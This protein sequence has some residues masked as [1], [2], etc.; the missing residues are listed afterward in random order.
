MEIFG[1]GGGTERP[2]Y[3]SPEL[4][5]LSLMSC[6]TLQEIFHLHVFCLLGKRG[7]LE[8]SYPVI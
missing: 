4:D 6:L 8:S 2:R 7:E 5:G 1:L 3:R